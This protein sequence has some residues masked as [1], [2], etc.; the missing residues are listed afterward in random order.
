EPGLDLVHL[1]STRFALF[2]APTNRA[3]S[4]CERW[5]ASLIEHYGGNP[6]PQQYLPQC[7]PDG[8]FSPVQC[9]GESTYCW[10]VDQEGRE[11]DGTR[12]HD[13][14]KPTFNPSCLF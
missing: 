10:C 1:V 5:R 2:A 9:Y 7:E 6:D 8:E 12:S 14:V 4:V 11:I 3:E 13:A